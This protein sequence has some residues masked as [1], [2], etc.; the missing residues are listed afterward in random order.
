MISIR[1]NVHEHYS[2]GSPGTV[3]EK[4]PYEKYMFFAR[5]LLVHVVFEKGPYEKHMFF[6]KYI[7]SKKHMFLKKYIYFLKKYICFLKKYVYFF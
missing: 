7:R 6:R 2:L 4:G 1:R 5:H 3:Y